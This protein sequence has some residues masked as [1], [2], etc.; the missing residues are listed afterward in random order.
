MKQF[1]RHI[2]LL[3]ALFVATASAWAQQ[4]VYKEVNGVGTWYSLYDEAEHSKYTTTSVN[5]NITICTHSVFTPSTG[6]LSFDTKMS[7]VAVLNTNPGAYTILVGGKSVD[8]PKKQTSYVTK[9]TTI[10]STEV[11]LEFKLKYDSYNSARN[12]YIDDVKLPLAKHILIADG[13]Y[14]K[15][16]ESVYFDDLLKG[17]CSEE[18]VV[19]LRSFLSAGNITIKSSNP[20]VFRV[21]SKDNT[22]DYTFNV[23][24]NACASSNGASGTKANGGTLGDISQYSI[25]IYFCPTEAESYNGTITISDGT[26][27]ATIS[28]S[29]KGLAKKIDFTWKLENNYL[30]GDAGYL[31]NGYELKD[32]KGNIITS[33]LHKYVTFSSSDDDKVVAIDMEKGTITAVGE[34]TTTITATFKGEEG[35]QPFTETLDIIISKRTAILTWPFANTGNNA[36][37]YLVGDYV[38]LAEF[39]KLVDEVTQEDVSR[40]VSFEIETIERSAIY[41]ADGDNDYNND[42]VS[43]ENGK[44]IAKN[45]GKAKLIASVEGGDVYNSF[46]SEFTLTI[47]KHTPVF[48]WNPN[49]LPYYFNTTIVNIAFSTNRD[50][51]CPLEYKTSDKTIAEVENGAL[52]IHGKGQAVS[53]TVSQAENAEYKKHEEPFPFTPCQRPDFAVPFRISY[54]LHSNSVTWGNRCTWSDDSTIQLSTTSLADGFVWEDD[55]KRIV[56]TFGGVPDKLYF[57]YHAST[58]STAE[59]LSY[60]WKVEESVN[61]TDWTEVWRTSHLDTEWAA[62]GAIDLKASTQYIRLSYTGNLAGYI[63]NITVSSLEGNSYLRAADGTYLSRGYKYGTQASV[64]PFGVVC[65]VSNFTEDNV[66]IY[67]RFQFVDNMQYLYETHDTEE[68]F[69]DDQTALNSANKWAIQ[70][71]ASGEFTMQSG[72]DLGNK[73]RYVT[74]KNNVLT[75]TDNPSE[76]TIWQME[77]PVEH[78][79]VLKEYMDTVAAWAASKDF[80]SD[81]KTLDDMRRYI[82]VQDFEKIDVELPQVDISEHAGEY[83]DGINGTLSAYDNTISGLEPGIYRLT[84]KAFYRISESGLAQKARNNDFESVLAY[85]YANDVKYP[86]Q[87]VYDSYNASQY[88]GSDELYD[89][90]YYPTLLQPSAEQAF[91]ESHRYL[92]DVYV[93]VEADAGE[94]TGTLRYGIKNPSYV[95]GAWLAY[96]DFTLTYIGRKEYIFEGSDTEN[97]KD[98][99]T[100]KNW[101]RGVV[102]SDCHNVTI[103]ADID[104]ISPT[105]IYGITIDENKTIHIQS[106]G[107]LTIG[108]EGIRGAKEGSISIDNTPEGAGF[109]KVH[110]EAGNKPEKVTVNYVNKAYDSG[111]PRDEVWQYMGAPGADMMMSDAEKTTIYHW[112]EVKGW[113]KQS[114]TSLKP[115]VGYA[116][117]Q[118]K[119]E[120]ATFTVTATPIIP[121]EV[122]EISL[123]VTPTG[124]GGSNLFVN[125]FLAPID[126]ATFTGDEFE[127]DVVQTFY[128]FN[129]GSWTQ[130]QNQGGSN[131]MNYGVSPGQYYALSPKGASLMDNQYD[132]T[133]IPP[134][135]GV[136]VVAEGNGGKI[137]LDYMKHVYNANASNRPMRAPQR[138][139]EDLKRVRLQV[140]SENSGADRMYVIQH[141]ECTAGYDNGYDAENIAVD[142]Q[143]S[144]YTDERAGQMEISVSDNI[145][146]TYIGFQAGCDSEYQLRITSIIGEELYLKDLENDVVMTL[147]DDE[148]YT[149]YA[150][151]NSTNNRRFLLLDR[152]PEEEDNGVSTDIDDVKTISL[153]IADKMVYVANAPLNSELVVYN[154]SGLAVAK[155]AVGYTPCTMDLSY[156]STGVYLLRLDD[157]AYKMVCK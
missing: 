68:M 40:M 59:G 131:H 116:F 36:G 74:I 54:N 79:L 46:V 118:N 101:N 102:P 107:G 127:G 94:T 78:D 157:E 114:G 71:N 41:K 104:I 135:Q 146:S 13:A 12:V 132:Q 67:S 33:E 156:L 140:N 49:L 95:P 103:K 134:M 97:P 58:F 39:Y 48:N 112:D 29:G 60:S 85:V 22:G 77:A 3:L 122:Q 92:N 81:V 76:A 152:S 72:N 149:F 4:P 128:L 42:V 25:K 137:K 14:G 35:W 88:D 17:Q 34:G 27:T 53:I 15:S 73:G 82:D 18:K 20:N 83:R 125:S 105:S 142:G 98:W 63:K 115:F 70:S 96:R 84:V 11:N 19:N 121:K 151:P 7:K 87:S 57:D 109:L 139:S 56:V 100:E 51:N 75:F 141:N 6:A 154:M 106:T 120:S 144:I 10:S 126:L 89:N 133:T 93:Y 111:N 147:V 55:Q 143:V 2:F 44:I 24:A 91:N 21:M 124:M 65:R 129:S 145:D 130:W 136:Y 50:A 123:T 45:A 5:N 43:I 8:L 108:K 138:T 47:D 28:V 9:T 69:T 32:A 26:S 117:T 155:Y 30:V 31:I 153:W 66:N 86:I 113:V 1:L 148:V 52:K 90:H 37:T 38:A 16:S 99:N 23:G 110:P 150:T 119:A 61:G 64:D 80:G 62:S